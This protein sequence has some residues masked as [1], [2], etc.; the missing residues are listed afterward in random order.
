MRVLF[1]ISAFLL[2]HQL[3]HAQLKQ[4]KFKGKVKST[5]IYIYDTNFDSPDRKY[6][7]FKGKTDYTISGKTISSIIFFRKS[8]RS[9]DFDTIRETYNKDGKVLTSYTHNDP[10][11]G[12]SYSYSRDSLNRTV[13]TGRDRNQLFSLNVIDEKSGIDTIYYYNLGK[14]DHQRVYNYNKDKSIYYRT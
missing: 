9:K 8:T 4:P 13:V 6:W 2:I 14:I 5:T 11:S 3:A 10:A 1:I 12:F 7:G